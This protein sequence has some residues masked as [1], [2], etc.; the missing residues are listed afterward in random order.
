MQEVEAILTAQRLAREKRKIQLVDQRGGLQ[1][2]L[3]PLVA[4][5][6][7]GEV[8]ELPV[9]GADQLAAGFFIAVAPLAE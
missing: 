3:I 9:D 8:V 5:A 2:A 7:G 1:A 4:N 6:A